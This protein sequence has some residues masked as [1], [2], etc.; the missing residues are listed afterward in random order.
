MR[1]EIVNYNEIW[2]LRIWISLTN[3]VDIN[4]FIRTLSRW[5]MEFIFNGII[6]WSIPFYD[7]RVEL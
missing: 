1:L 6:G 4:D 7:I 3:T 5:W 2:G